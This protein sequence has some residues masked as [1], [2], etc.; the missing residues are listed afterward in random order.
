MTETTPYDP[1]L[2]YRRKAWLAFG[3]FIAAFW[4]GLAVVVVG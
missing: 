4:I 3:C 1:N 2:H